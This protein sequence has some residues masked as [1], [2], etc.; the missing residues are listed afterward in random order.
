M[1]VSLESSYSEG[2]SLPDTPQQIES[3]SCLGHIAL[4]HKSKYLEVQ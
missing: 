1:Y 3:H 2:G 4:D